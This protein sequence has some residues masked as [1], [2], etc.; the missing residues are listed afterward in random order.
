MNVCKIDNV[1][2]GSLA[3]A[4]RFTGN[5]ILF[6]ISDQATFPFNYGDSAIVKVDIFLLRSNTTGIRFH[7]PEN[8]NNVINNILL[9]QVEV[10]ADKNIVGC[11]GLHLINS[12]RIT[13]NGVDLENLDIAI[14]EES[15]GTGNNVSSNNNFIATFV[16]GSNTSYQTSGVVNRR[17]FLGCDNLTPDNLADTDVMFP[18][19]LWLSDN[20]C[21]IEGPANGQLTISDGIG[22]NG[23]R[24][25]VRSENPIIKPDSSS[26]TASVTVG[27]NNSLGVTCLPGIVLPVYNTE[28]ANTIDGMIMQF[29][30]GVVG[31]NRGLYQLRDGVWEFIS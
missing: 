12:K 2:M 9:S 22:N 10:L 21:K 26:S 25:D 20:K 3:P 18:K 1:T 15:I 24:F 29:H 5:G 6:H 7:G 28:P 17:L 4:K 11:T 19:S 16:F 23:L 13:C 8:T 31:A 14:I 27:D 30:A